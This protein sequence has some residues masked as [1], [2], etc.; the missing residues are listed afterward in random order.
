MPIYINVVQKFRIRRYSL[1][2]VFTRLYGCTV[3]RLLL[4]YGCLLRLCVFRQTGKV[5]RKKWIE[6][7]GD[8]V[9]MRDETRPEKHTG[10]LRIR[11]G[12]EETSSVELF[13]GKLIVKIL[14]LKWNFTVILSCRWETRRLLH[15]E[16]SNMFSYLLYMYMLFPFF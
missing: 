5:K 2:V 8:K 6:R 11:S 13:A 14:K 1:C 16:F 7:K 15:L 4:V 12:K 10:R 3:R 9:G